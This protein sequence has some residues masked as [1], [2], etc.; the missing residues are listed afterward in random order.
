MWDF[1]GHETWLLQY[2]IFFI[3]A[4]RRSQFAPVI[5][6]QI[7]FGLPPHSFSWKFSPASAARK[8]S[9]KRL[10]EMRLARQIRFSFDEG[11]KLYLSHLIFTIVL[12]CGKTAQLFISG[13]C[14][15]VFGPSFWNDKQIY[16]VWH[17]HQ[18][19]SGVPSGKAELDKD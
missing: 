11:R 10:Q 17:Q 14:T 5:V 19:I 9:T 12:P 2:P 3:H 7:E 1:V 6:S 18:V 8:I 4:S 16:R 13:L 15:F